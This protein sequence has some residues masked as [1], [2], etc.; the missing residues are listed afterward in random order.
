VRTIHH[1]SI[2]EV[3]LSDVLHALSDPVRLEIVRHLAEHPYQTCGSLDPGLAKSTLSHH[4]KVLRETGITRTEVHG[5]QRL[6]SVR[7]ADVERRF[8][9]VLASVLEAS[10]AA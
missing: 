2:E 6:L 4:L 1:P 10:R 8:P 7:S 3:E 5:T 9:G